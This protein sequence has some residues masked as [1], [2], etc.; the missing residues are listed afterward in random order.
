MSTNVNWG[1]LVAQGR[2]KAHGVPWS[3]EEQKALDA[4][5]K[6][7]DVRSGILTQEDLEKATKE[8]RLYHRMDDAELAKAL[9]K[10][11][12]KREFVEADVTRD[13][14]LAEVMKLQEAKGKKQ[15]SKASD[16]SASDDQGESDVEDESDESTEDEAGS[17]EEE[18]DLESMKKDEL[19]EHAKSLGIEV[20]EDDTKATLKEKIAAQSK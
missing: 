18:V 10:L 8:G 15:S 17:E 1:Q 12:P 11:D 6:A 5:L 16:A 2:V 3:E 13:W 7:Q 14:L 20:T 19:V 4:G 9:R